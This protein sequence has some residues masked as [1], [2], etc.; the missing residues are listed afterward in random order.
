MNTRIQRDTPSRGIG[1]LA[2]TVGGLLLI[3][4]GLELLAHQAFGQTDVA[5][6]LLAVYLAFWFSVLGIVGFV[7]LAI[8]WLVTPKRRRTNR[9]AAPDELECPRQA[10]MP[11]VHSRELVGRR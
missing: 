5:T 4:L 3:S 8:A 6:L 1:W 9:V 10:M 11:V 7:V 2:G